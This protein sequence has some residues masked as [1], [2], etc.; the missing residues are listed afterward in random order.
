MRSLRL[1]KAN[2]C[3]L[4]GLLT[5][6]AGIAT[7]IAVATVIQREERA[8]VRTRFERVSFDRI[9]SLQASLQ[10]SV[11]YA[12]A[13]RAFFMS[14]KTVDRDEFHRFVQDI[15]ASQPYIVALEWVPAVAASDRAAFEAGA[16]GAIK[17]PVTRSIEPARDVYYPVLFSEPSTENRASLG[18]DYGSIPDCRETMRDALR[19][20]KAQATRVRTWNGSSGDDDGSIVQIFVA[21]YENGAGTL[22]TDSTR[23]CRGFISAV[24]RTGQMTEVALGGLELAGVDISF[25]EEGDTGERKLIRTRW[26]RARPESEWHAPGL[27]PGELARFDANGFM[28]SHRLD[29]GGLRW[30]VLTTPAPAFF[31][32]NDEHVWRLVLLGGLALSVV[33]GYITLL[34]LRTLLNREERTRLHLAAVVESSAD[35]IYTKSLA[36]TITS[37]NRAAER[38]L[39]FTAQEIIGKPV[40]VIQP[41][42]GLQ[43]TSRLMEP[44][45][46]ETRTRQ[47]ETVRIAKNGNPIDVS[48]SVSPIRNDRGDMIEAA[49]I[50]RD[51][52][53]QKRIDHLKDDFIHLASHQLRTPLSALRLYTDM[54]LEDYAGEL[55]PE[56]RDYLNIVAT[57]TQRMVDLVGTLLNI[58]RI[59]SAALMVQ[60][61]PCYFSELLLDVLNEMEG[62]I[63]GKQ[64]QLDADLG[65]GMPLVPLDPAIVHEILI[66]LLTNAVKYTPEGGAIHVGLAQVAERFVVSITD[67]GCGISQQDHDLVFSRFYRAENV[68]NE[69]EGSGMGLY[70]VKSLCEL[71]GCQI[72]FESQPDAGTTFRFAVPHAGM[73]EKSGRSQLE[74]ISRK[75]RFVNA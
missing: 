57:S 42:A 33:S 10:S 47:Y 58:S 75:E 73:R 44:R 62:D 63:K 7:S 24:F 11:N 27:Q 61:V 32:M 5:T 19:S 68:R 56:Q 71:S 65:S 12:E 23:V 29:V 48:L 70:L 20:G 39:G 35:A 28:V 59:D 3:L 51:I 31:D 18:L 22:A 72:S 66:N 15:L 54:L 49:V 1:K 8:R 2:L 4:A 38:L 45:D 53:E 67:T 25:Y 34:S 14:S 43:E 21:V 17:D 50:M 37:W 13:I 16:A 6:V 52:T 60:P 40:V 69:Q 46:N 9:Q 64:I 74:S 55:N 41:S 26:S 30:W 36:G